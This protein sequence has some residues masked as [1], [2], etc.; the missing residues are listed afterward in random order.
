[1]IL[2]ELPGVK[3]DRKNLGKFIDTKWANGNGE[4][5]EQPVSEFS[6]LLFDSE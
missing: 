2:G 6:F 5:L 1:V 4:A 3:A